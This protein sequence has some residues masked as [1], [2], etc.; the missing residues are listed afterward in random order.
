[1]VTYE[2]QVETLS[3]ALSLT[4]GLLGIIAPLVTLLIEW[5]QRH[6]YLSELIG[7]VFYEADDKESKPIPSKFLASLR[8]F[9][10]SFRDIMRLAAPRICRKT[11][12]QA[13][14]KQAVEY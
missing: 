5:I 11:D 10:F 12:R 9:S 8:R 14:Y 6:L 4:G 13:L 1:L 2:R 7:R 3:T